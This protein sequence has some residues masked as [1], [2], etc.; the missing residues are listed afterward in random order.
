MQS[1]FAKIL[2]S[3]DARLAVRFSTLYTGGNTP[4]LQRVRTLDKQ[5]SHEVIVNPRTDGGLGQLRTDGWGADIRPLAI[6]ETM[7]PNEN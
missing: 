5:V 1:R 2:F 7:R 4:T 6:S 3:S